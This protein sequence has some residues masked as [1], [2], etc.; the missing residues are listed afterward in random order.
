MPVSGAL[1]MPDRSTIENQTDKPGFAAGMLLYL[2]SV[3]LVG[4][5]IITLFGIAAVSSLNTD[6]KTL[7]GSHLFNQA[8]TAKPMGSDV[9]STRGFD[10]PP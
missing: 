9:F 7:K 6:S 8:V 3:G 2:T 10:A 1:L 4:A 5:A